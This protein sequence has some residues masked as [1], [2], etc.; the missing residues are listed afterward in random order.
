MEIV[1]LDGT[2]RIS[3]V[4]IFERDETQGNSEHQRGSNSNTQGDDWLDF[5]LFKIFT[6]KFIFMLVF[7]LFHELSIKMVAMATRTDFKVKYYVVPMAT[8]A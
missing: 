4:G 5:F 1:R 6:I 3:K 8:A 7:S 2:S